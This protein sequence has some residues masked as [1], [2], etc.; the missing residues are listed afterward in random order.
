MSTSLPLPQTE[1]LA[2]L[3]V[4]AKYF[5]DQNL[6]PPQLQMTP[7]WVNL[8]CQTSMSPL[9]VQVQQRLLQEQQPQY[10]ESGKHNVK[11]WILR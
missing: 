5:L 8:L 9:K 10:L 2:N 6:L 1:H 7:W 4:Q 3:W 11:N